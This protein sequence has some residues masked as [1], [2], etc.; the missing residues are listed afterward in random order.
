MQEHLDLLVGETDLE[1]DQSCLQLVYGY[2]LGAVLVDE[3]ETL[4]D[5]DVVAS[6]VLPYLSED[7]SLPFDSVL[8]IYSNIYKIQ[9]L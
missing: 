5:R 7:P 3:V 6:Q 1:P 9:S 2:G 8:L 4:L